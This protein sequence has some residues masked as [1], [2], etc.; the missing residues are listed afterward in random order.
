[1]NLRIAHATGLVAAILSLPLSSISSQA[2]PAPAVFGYK[3][4][5]A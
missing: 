3:S 2:Q 1:M 4:F 5:D